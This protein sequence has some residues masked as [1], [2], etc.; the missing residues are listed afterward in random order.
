MMTVSRQ[1]LQQLQQQQ[2]QQQQFQQQQILEQ[3]I[4][5]SALETA[6]SFEALQ[7]DPVLQQH[8]QF[9]STTESLLELSNKTETPV[10]IRCNYCTDYSSTLNSD[11]WEGI[12]NHILPV[13]K[14]ELQTTF[15][16]DLAKHFI[17][18]IRIQVNGKQVVCTKMETGAEQNTPQCE[19]ILTHSLVCRKTKR[20]F[21]INRP[22][23]SFIAN[24]AKHIRMTQP[25]Q[26]NRGNSLLCIFCNCPFTFE[27]YLRHIQP[28]ISAI[29]ATLSCFAGAYCTAS[30]QQLR[31]TTTCIACQEPETADLRFLPCTKFSTE[32]HCL[33][34]LQFAIECFRENF[35]DNGFMRL[36]TNHL[37]RCTVCKNP[38]Q[39]YCAVFQ[40]TSTSSDELG[41]QQNVD[42]QLCICINCQ[43]QFI[44][45]VMKEQGFDYKMK[46]YQLR[47]MEQ[48]CSCLRI[49]LGQVK[50]ICQDKKT[51]IYAVHENTS[52]AN[53][54]VHTIKGAEISEL[55]PITKMTTSPETEIATSPVKAFFVCD[56]CMFTVD[57]TSLIATPSN[58]HKNEMVS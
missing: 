16:G 42:S 47:N 18:S 4:A 41:V 8:Q 14:E 24:L 9:L 25:G 12:L 3:A 56:L 29:I 57:L 46:L 40:I 2:Q 26:G 21:I 31:A 44:N 6:Q 17:R 5:Q 43:K 32:Y 20:E 51:L 30:Y 28:H 45:I 35:G 23:A 50:T 48:L 22:D 55:S 11:T 58:R 54:T 49:I 1:Q 13:C 15:Y 34:K 38:Q 10:F 33:S 36:T 7:T 52:N 53:S 37:A 19:V 39:V 27:D